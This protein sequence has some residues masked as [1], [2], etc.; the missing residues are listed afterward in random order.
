MINIL[1]LVIVILVAIISYFVGVWMGA[2][3]AAKNI[4][5][6]FPELARKQK[7]N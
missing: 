3:E 4:A 5:R 2:R 1:W 6:R 7:E